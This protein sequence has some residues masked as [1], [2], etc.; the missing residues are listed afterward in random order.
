M[1]LPSNPVG[2]YDRTEALRAATETRGGFT[3]ILTC[4]PFAV[5]DGAAADIFVPILIL[6]TPALCAITVAGVLDTAVPEGGP[7][8]G[9]APDPA[10]TLVFIT[11]FA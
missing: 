8:F 2:A 4:F 10:A 7:G 9:R 6:R 11:D 3:S 5:G 1:R